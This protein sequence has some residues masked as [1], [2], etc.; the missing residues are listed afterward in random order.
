M[1]AFSV[2]SASAAWMSPAVIDNV[3]SSANGDYTLKAT[4]T[5]TQT[6]TILSTDANAKS[7][8]AIALTAISAGMNVAIEYT[9]STIDS[10]YLLK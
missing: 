5:W 3:R 1:A 4:G 2:G 10:I 6:F 8:L 9:G 7:L